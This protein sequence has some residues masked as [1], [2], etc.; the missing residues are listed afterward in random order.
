MPINFDKIPESIGFSIP[1]PGLYRMHVD[2]TAMK[3]AY[4][5]TDPL[6]LNITATLYDEH[7]KNCGK[8]F[9]KFRDNPNETAAKRNAQVYKIGRFIKATGLQV[10]GVATLKDI[11]KIIVGAEVIV[12]INHYAPENTGK[13]YAQ[14]NLF[15]GGCYYPVSEYAKLL[16]EITAAKDNLA[17]ALE[18]TPKNPTTPMETT[19]GTLATETPSDKP[20][21]EAAQT[22][23]ENFDTG[24]ANP[25]GY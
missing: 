16:G 20:T 25:G 18:E 23:L 4:V 1:E 19:T 24:E 11:S 15:G 5:A 8:F 14:A 9:D 21:D 10:T 2:S 7:G 22:E 6:E 13:V 17:T 12:D 3:V